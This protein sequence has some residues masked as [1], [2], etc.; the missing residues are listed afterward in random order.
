[1]W[2]HANTC[3]LAGVQASN[4]F[5]AFTG[6]C[7]NASNASGRGLMH[8]LSPE[9]CN[10]LTPPKCLHDEAEGAKTLNSGLETC[11]DP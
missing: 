2:A 3:I 1:M 5:Q 10:A 4:G 9:I 8:G 7:M 11:Y 6:R